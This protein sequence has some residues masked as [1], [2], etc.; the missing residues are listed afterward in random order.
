[1]YLAPRYETSEL[2]RVPLPTVVCIQPDVN[3][4]NFRNDVEGE[5]LYVPTPR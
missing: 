4:I 5:V 2:L 1:M 3:L